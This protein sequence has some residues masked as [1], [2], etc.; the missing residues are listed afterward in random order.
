[1]TI[2]GSP[3]G[4]SDA[5][6]A[7][8]V[9]RAATRRRDS[10]PMR[11]DPATAPLSF[12]Q[13]R[14][15]LYEQLEPESTAY[16]SPVALRIEGPLDA[17]A[18]ERALG[19]IV[20]RHEILRT[21]FA[22]GP[23]GIPA[24][25]I[26][27]EPRFEFIREDVAG[28][29]DGWLQAERRM[30]EEGRRPFDLGR[31]LPMRAHLFRVE[32]DLHLFLVVFHHIACDGWSVG[33]FLGELDDAYR[34]AVA[35]S[36]LNPEP[37]PVQYG[38]YAVWQRERMQGAVLARELAHWT[39]AI[40]DAA[41]V[42][43]LPTDR[44]RSVDQ[45][46]AAGRVSRVLDPTLTAAL[47]DVGRAEGATLFMT[48]AA[49]LQVLLARYA[50][51]ED[52][53]IG[54]P[55]AGRERREIEQCLG[56]FINTLALRCD[57]SGSPTFRELVR[58]VGKGV[59]E[60]LAHQ[61]LPFEQLVDA[62]QP[63]RDRQAAPLVQVL[64]NFRNLP[65]A[66]PALGELNVSRLDYR[67]DATM[68]DLDFEITE[69]EGGLHCTA[70]YAESLFDRDTIA[71]MLGHFERLL[72]AAVADPD[73]AAL[74]L[75]LLS[76]DER[77]RLLNALG[78]A[79]GPVPSCCIHQMIAERAALAP[80][81]PA[82]LGAGGQLTY[83]ELLARAQSVA[84]TLRREGV[85]RG[86][87]VGLSVAR[88]PDLIAGMLGIMA[89]GAAYV[90]LDPEYPDDRLAFIIADASLACVLVDD[91]S[92]ARLAHGT[93]ARLV[94][95][96]A[97]P[98]VMPGKAG[99]DGPATPD[100][101]AYVIY[102]SGSTGRP[103]GV[104]IGHRA[105]AAF[106][107]TTVDGFELTEHDRV[108]Q[109]STP[110]FD[111]SVVEIFPVLLAG[112]AVVLRNAEMAESVDAFMSRCEEWGVTIAIPPTAFW[113]EM[114]GTLADEGR[115]IPPSIRL[116]AVGGERM[117]PERATLWRKVAPHAAL[118]N[119]YGPTET[120][121]VVTRHHMPAGHGDTVRAVPIGRPLP[122]ARVF[123]LDSH[124]NLVP[125]GVPGELYIGGVQLAEGYLGRPDLTAERFVPSPFTPGERLYRSG[126]IVRWRPDGELEYI[127]RLDRQVKVRGFR[128]EIGEVESALLE[129]SMV[130]ECAVEAVSGPGGH[131]RLIAY[132]VVRGTDQ[133]G[134][135][136]AVGE[137]LRRRLPAFMVP[138]PII[139]VPLIPR[140]A[141]GKADRAAL[142]P[143][144]LQGRGAERVRP[145]TRSHHVLVEIWER[146][147]SVWPVGIED[148][149]FALGGNS[150][151]AMQM[152]TEVRRVF[153][154]SLQLNALFESPTIAGIAAHLPITPQ[155]QSEAR[156]V[157]LN[158]NGARPPLIFFHPDVV[159]SGLYCRE[160][161]RQVGP[162]QPVYLVGPTLP[163]GPATIEAAAAAD[164]AWIRETVPGPYRIGG[165]CAAGT[166]AYETAR[167]LREQ[168]ETVQLL[169]LVESKGTNGIIHRWRRLIPLLAWLRRRAGHD[170]LSAQLHAV[171]AL[172][173]RCW[174]YREWRRQPVARRLG[175]VIRMARR[176]RHRRALA[177]PSVPTAQT[178]VRAAP[179]FDAA[180]VEALAFSTRAARA[181]VP[182]RYA[183]RV[184]LVLSSSADGAGGD[185]RQGWGDVAASLDIELVSASHLD[186]LDADAPRL[187]R[188]YLEEL[189]ARG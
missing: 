170:D 117:L 44:S 12:V 100:D 118:V 179:L 178:P 116:M 138:A 101:A 91:V 83:A 114:V 184:R 105:L 73:G 9:E 56:C 124:R 37:L 60:G 166:A 61:A 163:G 107:A 63:A 36:G 38:D 168:G 142:P 84:T 78:G 125:L 173:A 175:V 106:S 88:S 90:P 92:H 14:I 182:R 5:A 89:A 51:Q 57:L 152:V 189:D 18:L 171:R 113:H 70:V 156:V 15:W 75:P 27:V 161:V 71:R 139:P 47:R 48:L 8:L 147:L 24:Q 183:G 6:H 74:T 32:P 165:Y 55:E 59:A 120:T 127:G 103:K 146:L 149:F 115:T 66:A 135:L 4:L 158:R 79:T 148:D 155:H 69:I 54:M 23:D 174:Q 111:A 132:V 64:F 154:R 177:E 96:A 20:R 19:G 43:A 50:D 76:A 93:G 109:F 21:T 98:P 17:D 128:V 16:H 34:S 181:F 108:L 95:L 52:F 145:L 153:G 28:G 144:D 133:E 42:L 68:V 80:G 104:V 129:S 94:S 150:L 31:E 2:T 77:D 136:A 164:V 162:E 7:L 130:A 1:M 26:N 35:G 121:V 62:V 122:G 10:I 99:C 134:G 172:A 22:A 167:L 185:L 157:A 39:A 30:A 112:A 180:D 137:H 151:L 143:P 126:D 33:L 40:G 141:N 110:N 81:A 140:T 65:P 46:P 102:T 29:S 187:I 169:V 82:I 186:V 41:T 45:S 123:V 13:Q 176:W 86:D 87:R 53:L 11:A 97:C 58:R 85:H 25:T 119:G 159:G 131:Q 3:A 160:I 188:R 67:G 49:G 72:R